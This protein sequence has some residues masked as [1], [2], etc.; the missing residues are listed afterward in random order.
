[1]R[2]IF[3]YRLSSGSRPDLLLAEL[4]IWRYPNVSGSNLNVSVD[5]YYIPGVISV[6]ISTRFVVDTFR[7]CNVRAWREKKG[8]PTA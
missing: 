7:A 8:R 4:K 5:F 1:M 6:F 3:V 2:M